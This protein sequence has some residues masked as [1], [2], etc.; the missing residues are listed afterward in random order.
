MWTPPVRPHARGWTGLLALAALTI[1][2]TGCDGTLLD[3]EDPDNVQPAE[4]LT[5]ADV[6]ARLAG[7]VNDFNNMYDFYV[8]Y[9][10]LLTDEFVLAGTFPTREEIDARTPNDDNGSIDEN[11]WEPLQVSRATADELDRQLTAGIE[12]GAFAD[13]EGQAREAQTIS[14][15]FG[16]YDR[17]LLSELFCQSIFGGQA[18]VP[19]F[20][21][22]E[23]ETA[24]LTSDERMAEARDV[25]ASAGAAATAAG[26]EP[27]RQAALIGQARAELWLGNHQAA[28]DLVADVPTD[29]VFTVDYSDQTITL[30]NEVFQQTWNINTGG[31]RWTVGNGTD[32]ARGNERW[33]YLDEWIGQG[34]LIPADIAADEVGVAAFNGTSPVTLQTLYAGR[35][36]ST[37]AD[38]PIVLA[39]GWEARM[40]EAENEIRNGDPEVAQQIVNDLLTDPDQPANPIVLRVQP[41]LADPA[42]S[43]AFVTEQLAAFDPVDFTGDPAS[44]LT[45]LARARSAGLWLTGERQAT[46]R[47]FISRDGLDLYP[48]RRGTAIS[49]PVPDAEVDN[50][51]N[52]SQNCPSG[53]P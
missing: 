14:R 50:N 46:F 27:E 45:Q 23:P 10:G 53:L 32:P 29:F 13:I 42:S 9:A 24:P 49:L 25:L 31:L 47:R 33:A 17:V 35:D 16:G 3:V 18:D 41:S 4:S 6:P 37:G 21:D 39:S 26:L 15:L 52:I 38:A 1:T 34:L 43:S 40:I 20:G 30:E 48:V 5:P 44:D 28:A 51:E 12:S 22:E 36:G 7:V 8:L 11:V 19:R 2:L